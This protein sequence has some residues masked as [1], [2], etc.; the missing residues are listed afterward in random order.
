MDDKL[1][2]IFLSVLGV[3][4]IVVVSV[5]V[6]FAFFSYVK[7]GSSNNQ[8]T[9]GK[10]AFSFIDGQTLVLTNH[11]PMDS[12]GNGIGT[13]YTEITDVCT[14]TITGS[15][16]PGVTFKYKVS[17][18]PGDKTLEKSGKKR[19]VYDEVFINIKRKDTDPIGTFTGNPKYYDKAS[20]GIVLTNDALE[21]G[22]GTITPT[23]TDSDAV[24]TF[25]VRMWVDSSKVVIT[26]TPKEGETRKVYSTEEYHNLYYSMKI[27]VEAEA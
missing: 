18:V 12:T 22:T 11:F 7:T 8:I 19:L 16:S 1:K 23:E 13:P 20:S 25:E 14:F 3:M 24:L 5:G 27:L 2:K 9:T 4:I 17:A 6:S 21:L 10:L 26:D 15:S